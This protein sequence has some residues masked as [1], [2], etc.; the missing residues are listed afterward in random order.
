MFFNDSV[1]RKVYFSAGPGLRDDFLLVKA[2]CEQKTQPGE[3]RRPQ[4]IGTTLLGLHIRGSGSLHMAPRCSRS[5]RSS[6]G[7]LQPSA[8]PPQAAPPARAP[9]AAVRKFLSDAGRTKGAEAGTHLHQN[10]PTDEGS[11]WVE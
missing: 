7:I 8:H 6:A 9:I 4:G 1:I 10:I 5:S 3:V 11:A 2:L